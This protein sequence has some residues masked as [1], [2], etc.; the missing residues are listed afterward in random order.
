MDIPDSLIYA[1]RH[2]T[3]WQPQSAGT[4]APTGAPAAKEGPNDVGHRGATWLLA[5]FGG[6]LAPSLQA[7]RASRPG[8]Q[9]DSWP[10]AQAGA[11]PASSPRAGTPEGSVGGRLRHR[12]LD[13]RPDCPCDPA[14]VQGAL[15]SRS[16]LEALTAVGLELSEAGAAGPPAQRAGHR[17]LGTRR[18]APY[19]KRLNGWAPTSSSSTRAASRSPQ[20][21]NE[22]GLRRGR[23]RTS[24]IGSSATSSRPSAPSPSRPTSAIWD[25]TS[26]WPPTGPSLA[27]TSARSSKPC[28]AICGARWSCSGTGGRS[29]RAGRCRCLWSL[30]HGSIP[31]TSHL[32]RR[33][34]I[35]RSI[36][37][38][39]PTPRWPM[40]R[41]RMWASC[42]AGSATPSASYVAPNSCCGRASLPPSFPGSGEDVHCLC[43]IQ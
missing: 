20:P 26:A 40:G 35:R 27:W 2:A 38:T 43:K 11:T 17:V 24:T 1:G 33:N 29:T 5:Q 31:M 36:S 32:T 25:S 21:S 16:R 7:E 30:I 4:A 3:S 10:T 6:A 15:P 13:A 42:E 28:C 8:P 18:L 14:A 41:R 34:S 12:S 37:G 39:R 9:A 19:K 22:P 23:R